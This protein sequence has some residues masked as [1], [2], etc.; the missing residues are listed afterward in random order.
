MPCGRACDF[1][2]NFC[3]ILSRLILLFVQSIMLVGPHKPGAR[4]KSWAQFAALFGWPCLYLLYKIARLFKT[5]LIS[6]ISLFVI[7]CLENQFL[8]G[9][10]IE[11]LLPY[12]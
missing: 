7:R 4:G 8:F 10:K 1:V 11:I 5:K 6:I 12:V 3:T 2:A 9:N